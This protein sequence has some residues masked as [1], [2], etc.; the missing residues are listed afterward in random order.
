MGGFCEI[1]GKM[2]SGFSLNVQEE[3]GLKGYGFMLQQVLIRFA[4]SCTATGEALECV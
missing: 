2:Y 4:F 1:F 3:G